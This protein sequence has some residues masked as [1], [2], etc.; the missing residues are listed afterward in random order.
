MHGTNTHRVGVV[1]LCIVMMMLM[2]IEPFL[3]YLIEFHGFIIRFAVKMDRNFALQLRSE[4]VE[5]KRR[6]RRLWL[7][8]LLFIIIIIIIIVVLTRN[9]LFS[10]SKQISMVHSLTWSTRQTVYSFN[11]EYKRCETKSKYFLCG[12]IPFVRAI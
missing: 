7:Y 11:H 8:Y 3:Q 12:F 5:S 6:Y 1:Y 9:R 10:T 4:S 2:M